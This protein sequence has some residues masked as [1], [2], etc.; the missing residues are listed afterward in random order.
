MNSENIDD[1]RP[2]VWEIFKSQ[3]NTLKNIDS[4]HDDNNRI[5]TLLIA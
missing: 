2:E 5:G 1:L 4:E 3:V